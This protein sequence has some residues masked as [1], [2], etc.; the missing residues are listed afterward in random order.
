MNQSL[1][2]IIFIGLN[3]TLFVS[4]GIPLLLSTTQVITESEQQIAI[5]QFINEVD[6]GVFFS[7]QNGI[8]VTRTIYVPVN[9][10]VTS[11]HHH[12]IFTFFYE[13][14][15]TTARIYQHKVT[16][17]GPTSPGPHFLEITLD[18]VT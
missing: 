4:V 9:I 1:E 2:K 8:P 18:N 7:D 14:W 6:E 10:T 12:L 5:Q 3:L 17:D 13:R 15:Y 16:V 11:Q